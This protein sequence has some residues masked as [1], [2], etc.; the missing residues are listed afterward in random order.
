MGAAALAVAGAAGWYL[1]HRGLET[2]DNAQ[3]DAN[4]VAVPARTAGTVAH[5]LFVENQKVHAGDVLAELDDAPT[6]ARLAQAEATLA[7]AIASADAADA[8]AV[9]AESNAIGNKSFADASLQ[10]ARAGVATTQDQI[11]EREAQV[12]SAEAALAQAKLD[13]DR[14]KALFDSGAVAKS[15]FDQ[16]DTAFNRASADLDA[17]RS[18]LTTE[19]LTVTQTRSKVAEADAKAKQANNVPVLVRQAR[20]KAAQAHAQVQMAQAQRDLAALDFSYTKILAPH[21]GVVSKKTINEGQNVALGQTIVQLVTPEIYLTGNFKETQVTN[22][23]VG[24][25][26]HFKVDAFPGRELEGEVES[27]SGA[28]GSR[29][30]LLPPDNA[31]GNFTKIVQRLPVRIKLHAAPDGIVLRPG[32]SVDVTVDTRK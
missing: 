6:K 15:V 21:D 26:A 17:A 19:K 8:D 20:A 23:H 13:R 1:A 9:V 22:M 30:T 16:A 29:F 18:R 31:T 3:I 28:T 12:Q 27:L 11:K 32:M 2:T 5:I 24:Q 14:A 4:I 7:S 10:T 25:P